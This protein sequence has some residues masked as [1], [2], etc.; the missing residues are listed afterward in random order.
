VTLNLGVVSTIPEN[1][2][3][4]LL[5]GPRYDLSERELGILR[6]YW[7]LKRSGLLVMLDP[8]SNTPRLD[9]FLTNAGL[10]PRGD[11]VL[12]AES[13]ATGVKKQFSVE[14]TFSRESTLTRALKDATTTLSAQTQS[15][16][17]K[18][19]DTRLR[20]LAITLTPL[21]FADGRYWGEVNYLDELPTL[22]AEDEPPP[23]VLAASA[24][25]GAVSDER[26]R[27][28]SARLVV[29]GNAALLDARTRHPANQDFVASALNWMMNRER[30]IGPPPKRKEMYRVQL[31]PRQHDL[32]FQVTALAAPALVLFIGFTIWAGRRAS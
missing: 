10:Q 27:V 24:E 8:S 9:A 3:G 17:I 19:D 31:T 23:L 22:E 32:V 4:V 15:L 21:I 5:V 30:M 14:A 29:I 26:L 20:E 28:D 1:A 7:E 11:R 18:L 25:R 2:S 16:D 12:F 6:S 13:T